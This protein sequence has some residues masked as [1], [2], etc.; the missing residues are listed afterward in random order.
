[1]L[2]TNQKTR[3]IFF[4]LFLR[5]FKDLGKYYCHKEKTTEFRNVVCDQYSDNIHFI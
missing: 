1:M 5:F 3:L 2:F 4:W